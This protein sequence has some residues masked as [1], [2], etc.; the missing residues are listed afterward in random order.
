MSN[1]NPSPATRFKPGQSGNPKG[2][3]P[4]GKSIRQ[5][6][7]ETAETEKQAVINKMLA[8]AKVGDVRAAEWVAKYS[9]DPSQALL[10]I[11]TRDFTFKIG[12]PDQVEEGDGVD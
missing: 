5:L 7:R 9:D 2:G 10:E 8:L 12:I 4:P 6:L 11:A 1:P 3:H